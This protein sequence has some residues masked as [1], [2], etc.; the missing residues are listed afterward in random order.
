[1]KTLKNIAPPRPYLVLRHISGLT[2]R[3]Q[4]WR[5]TRNCPIVSQCLDWSDLLEHGDFRRPDFTRA[6]ADDILNRPWRH[7]GPLWVNFSLRW[8]N[9]DPVDSGDKWFNEVECQARDRKRWFKAWHRGR[10]HRKVSWKHDRRTKR[11]LHYVFDVCQDE[12]EPPI[13]KGACFVRPLGY[14]DDDE[15]YRV[16]QKCWK[17]QSKRKHQWRPR[18]VL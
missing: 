1:M 4:S 10:K 16:T 2:F 17:A 14:L 18:G 6:F 11:H 8:D 3:Y 15:D 12:G 7:I 13:R 5:A 9:G